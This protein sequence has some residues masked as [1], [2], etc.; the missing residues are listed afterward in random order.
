MHVYLAREP[1]LCARWSDG[2]TSYRRLGD[3]PGPVHSTRLHTISPATV[4]TPM[5][6]ITLI[7]AMDV[8]HAVMPS[9]ILRHAHR[10]EIG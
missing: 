10:L 4:S 1:A 7:A 5:I 2:P 6:I 8:A 9:P 3:R